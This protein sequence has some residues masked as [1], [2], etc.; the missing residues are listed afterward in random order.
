[1]TSTKL[2]SFLLDSGFLLLILLTYLA[3]LY[4][5]LYADIPRAER[6]SFGSSSKEGF[7]SMWTSGDEHQVSESCPDILVQSGPFLYLY[8]TKQPRSE[9]MNPIVFKGLNEYTVFIEAQ[10]KK[11]I[12][13][14]ILFLQKTFTAGGETVYQMRPGPNNLEGGLSH[15]VDARVV[16]VG[17]DSDRTTV[18]RRQLID[19]S[20]D[21]NLPFNAQQFPAFDPMNLDIGKI[22]PLDE[23][24]SYKAKN[25]VLSDD[26]MDPN[27]GGPAFS[28]AVFEKRIKPQ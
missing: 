4:F 26:P 7:I 16:G 1:M 15:S 24:G 21:Q 9:G 6:P 8:N 25:W 3:G 23:L 28:A 12:K 20:R 11:G 5:Y 19:A 17:A 14:P 2:L 27:W 18:E 10:R 22:T 13:C